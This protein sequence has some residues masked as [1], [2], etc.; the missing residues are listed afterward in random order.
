MKSYKNTQRWIMSEMFLNGLTLRE[1]GKKLEELEKIHGK[2][3]IKVLT[4]T[5]L[6]P[7]HLV[8]I[9]V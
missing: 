1:I 4:L 6:S 8:T 7:S 2:R 3:S 5:K 9:L